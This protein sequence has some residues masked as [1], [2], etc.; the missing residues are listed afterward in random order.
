MSVAVEFESVSR[1]F[2]AVTAVDRIDLG[3][4]EGSFFAMLGPSGSGKTS[5]LRLI[6]GFDRPSDGRIRIFGEDSND[7]PPS[8]ADHRT[9]PCFPI[10]T[11]ARTSPTG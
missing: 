7:I 9:M 1:R 10:W 8:P 6:S 11:S 3:I 4:E 5:C 2:G